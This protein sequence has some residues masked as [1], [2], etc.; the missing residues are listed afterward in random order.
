MNFGG[1]TEQAKAI[2]IIHGA[3]D[4]GINIIDSA[5]VYGHDPGNFDFGR[6]RCEEIVGNALK[7]N[8]KRDQVILATKVHYSMGDDP[9]ARGNSRK[10]ILDQCEAS[11]RRLQTDYIDLYQLHG[12]SPE[13][14]FDETLRALDDLVRSGMVRYIGTSGFAA[15]EILEGLW[16]SKEYGLNRFV[17]E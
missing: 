7:Q 17:S 3:I 9:N 11:L 2:E 16:V 14:P 12:T 13:F 5:N 10:H 1:R 4:A 6:G 15:W 8:G